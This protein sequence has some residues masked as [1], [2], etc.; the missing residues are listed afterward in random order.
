MERVSVLPEPLPLITMV[1]A[2]ADVAIAQYAALAEYFGGPLWKWL[3]GEWER[4]RVGM[5]ANA[6]KAGTD[7][8]LAEAQWAAT[9]MEMPHRYARD[10]RERA[11][12]AAN[13]RNH[14]KLPTLPKS[15]TVEQLDAMVTEA[16][17][18]CDTVA[19]EGYQVWARM[20]TGMAW[21]HFYALQ[22]CPGGPD[23]RY[24]QGAL[25]G[26]GRLF[27][28]LQRKV[29]LGVVAEVTRGERLSKRKGKEA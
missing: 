21:G 2:L 17:V 11:E 19:T 7:E 8:A 9:L 15:A 25:Q 3:A 6:V 23:R 22:S 26:I 27:G 20:L 29:D 1:P 24:H 16:Q 14:L 18:V 5:Q 13:E 4:E 12:T 28:D 10:R